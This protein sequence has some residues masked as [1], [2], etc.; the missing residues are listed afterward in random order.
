[1]ANP[2]Q[3]IFYKKVCVSK[4]NKNK[5]LITQ[6]FKIMLSTATFWFKE[7]PFSKPTKHG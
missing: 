2:K 3:E 5:W 1:M 6:R 4:D 7:V